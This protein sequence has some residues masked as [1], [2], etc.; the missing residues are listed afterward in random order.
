MII[1]LNHLF[2][3]QIRFVKEHIVIA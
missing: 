3:Q 1:T 2:Y